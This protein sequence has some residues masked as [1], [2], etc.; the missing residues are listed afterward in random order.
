MVI[1]HSWYNF[2]TVTN[3]VNGWAGELQL[4]PL[5][6]KPTI[7]TVSHLAVKLNLNFIF[8]NYQ[9]YIGLLLLYYYYFLIII[10]IFAPASTRPAG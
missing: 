1:G 3:M 8:F 6:K 7:S 2:T 9:I 10:I 5:K 4:I